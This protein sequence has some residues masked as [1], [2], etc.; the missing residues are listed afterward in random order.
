MSS[1]RILRFDLPRP[2]WSRIAVSAL[3]LGTACAWSAC[4]G[5]DDSRGSTGDSN[6]SGSSGPIGL[7]SLAWRRPV[8]ADSATNDA[9]ETVVVATF[10][11]DREGAPWRSSAPGGTEDVEFLAGRDADGKKRLVHGTVLEG[12]GSGKRL[13]IDLNGIDERFNEVIVEAQTFTRR[14]ELV[15]VRARSG[16]KIVASSAGAKLNGASGL[17]PVVLSLPGTGGLQG[18]PESLSV[19]FTGNKDDR[20]VVTS[21][22]L[23]RRE[24]SRY[25]PSV[26][27]PGHR[28]SGDHYRESVG[29]LAGS[30]LEI[31]IPD[32][33][34]GTLEFSLAQVPGM[35]PAGQRLS[36]RV[37]V[38]RGDREIASE[39]F[40]F[41][42][43]ASE[44]EALGWHDCRM[45]L[46]SQGAGPAVVSLELLGSDLAGGGTGVPT[47]SL[48]STPALAIR[49]QDPEIEPVPT[50][51]L[52]TSDTHRAD[53][54]GLSEGAKLVFTPALDELGLA[55]VNF[56]NC[57]S[58]TNV[59]SP[60]HAALLTGMHPRD[61]RIVTNDVRLS[62]RANTLA[63]HFQ[64]AGYATFAVT[65]APH[66]VDPT[67]G[68]GQGF[69]RMGGSALEVRDAAVSV[70][71]ARDWMRSAEGLPVFLWLHLFDA[72]DPYAPPEPFSGRY[73]PE[74]EDPRDPTRES[75]LSADLIPAWGKGVTDPETFFRAEYRA[76]IDYLDSEL[77]RLLDE[78]RV[79]A[80]I[81]AFTADHGENFGEHQIWFS[82]GGLYPSTL[83][84]PLLMRWPGGPTHLKT[85]VPVRQIDVGR[86]LLNLAGLDAVDHPGRDLRWAI[87]EPT[88]TNPRF[89]LSVRGVEAGVEADGW[90]LNLSL[91]DHGLLRS[92]KRRPFGRVELFHLAEDPEAA[93][94]VLQENL[95]RA[96]KMRARLIEWLTSGEGS[97]LAA[98]SETSEELVA[99]LAEL[100]YSG[101]DEEASTDWWDPET[102]SGGAWETSPWRLLFED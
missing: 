86:T 56:L 101:S 66:L 10:R 39:T 45:D 34:G 16:G 49:S 50:V 71:Q 40:D 99:L 52:I 72:H 18:P 82:H 12:Q 55:G 21:V 9:P 13:E 7:Q 38:R 27:S 20:I 4:S 84:I 47:L 57:Y 6:A 65:S 48:V 33:A 96:R 63:E 41:G 95:P 64:D 102:R 59:T 80:G 75:S 44:S 8:G 32:I 28:L 31:D 2:A 17:Q 100:G 23:L 68:F 54:I 42:A 46:S 5:R 37:T 83:H 3:L 36:A 70:A 22:T 85:N 30:P 62:E 89:F 98:E 90:L 1:L 81:T 11:P 77:A 35:T 26:E 15:T 24:W 58:S 19:L 78:P 92:E 94:D 91:D 14:G 67:S 93:V 29:L 43:A 76:E 79:R 69:R 60:S 51:V 97:G 88:L 74:D 53:H 61:T 25:L 87:D 73:Y